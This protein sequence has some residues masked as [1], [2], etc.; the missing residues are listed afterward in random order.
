MADACL[1]ITRVG[2]AAK[3]EKACERQL[4]ERTDLVRPLWV[5]NEDGHA[6]IELRRPAL[7][8]LVRGD[9]SEFKAGQLLG[10]RSEI[11]DTLG[12]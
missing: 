6:Q 3:Q 11:Y 5:A 1:G 10:R 2:S 7:A 8:K 12:K 9:C 4:M